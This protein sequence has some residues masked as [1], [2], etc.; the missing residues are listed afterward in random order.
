MTNIISRTLIKGI[1]IST[2]IFLL[3]TLI[4]NNI[5][6]AIECCASESWVF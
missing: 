6:K 1:I 4:D 2:L 3:M 5:A